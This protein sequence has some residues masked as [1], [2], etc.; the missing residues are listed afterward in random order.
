MTNKINILLVDDHAVVRMGYK[1][2]LSLS[3]SIGEIYEADRG[4][5]ACQLFDQHKPDVILLDLSMPGIGGFETI[6]RLIN[7]DSNC[8]ILVFSVHDEPLYAT[9]AIKAGAKGYVTKN[10]MP[11]ELVNAV[12]KVY[13][14]NTYV[15]SELAQQI[16][17]T[18]SS[19]NGDDK[20]GKINL[21]SPREFD[22]FSLLAN[23]YTTKQIAEQLHLAYK[24]VCNHGTS[25][26]E[27]LGVTSVAELTL[28]AMR[29]GIIKF[30]EVGN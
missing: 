17:A 9:R 20:T 19:V 13:Q 3:S 25:I 30:E 16:I 23:G 22:I 14:G 7:R 29:E 18:M 12:Y 28:L 24:T 21:L 11:E 10:S 4:E 8:K 27:K 6:K 5:V 15:S 1:T 26:R 2:Y